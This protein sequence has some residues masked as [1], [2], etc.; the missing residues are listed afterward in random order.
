MLEKVISLYNDEG[1]IILSREFNSDNKLESETEYSY[2]HHN[3]LLKTDIR[4][5][6]GSDIETM[7]NRYEYVYDNMNNWIKCI[8]YAAHNELSSVVFRKIV[9]Y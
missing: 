4:N 3:N 9:Y 2:D 6:S 8:H 7:Q 5:Y 1:N